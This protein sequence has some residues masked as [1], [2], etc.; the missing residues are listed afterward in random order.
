MLHKRRISYHHSKKRST[1]TNPQ[2]GDGEQYLKKKVAAGLTH[3]HTTCFT[4]L[5][6]VISWLLIGT[7]AYG[8]Q[9]TTETL[10]RLPKYRIVG[11]IEISRFG[12]RSNRQQRSPFEAKPTLSN[13][14]TRSNRYV[15][16]TLPVSDPTQ[17]S[18]VQ[19]PV[20]FWHFIKSVII[21]WNGIAF[22]FHSN[23]EEKR[24]KS[25][26]KFGGIRFDNFHF[27]QTN[28]APW[29]WRKWVN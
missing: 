23:D 27:A 10:Y 14:H 2:S 11:E 13:K 5:H 17:L 7:R 24:E 8:M 12:A 18:S 4:G 1:D 22:C 20:Q 26:T 16:Y 6:R 19:T 15:V 25:K 3:K 9:C 21:H 29:L 28:F